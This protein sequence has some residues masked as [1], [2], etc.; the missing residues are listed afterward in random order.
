[1]L[2][3]M[4]AA[5]PPSQNGYGF[6]LGGVNGALAGMG[7]GGGP[8]ANSACDVDVDVVVVMSGNREEY[9]EEHTERG[10]REKERENIYACD[11]GMPFAADIPYYHNSLAQNG[12]PKHTT[13][14]HSETRHGVN[15]LQRMS[16]KAGKHV[17]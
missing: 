4:V 14:V 16:E 5:T 2:A 8:T 13:G 7:V 9:G 1:M 15:K 6:F 10:Q 17:I 12:L 3:A 11:F